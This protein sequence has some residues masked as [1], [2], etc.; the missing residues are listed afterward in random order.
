MVY[1]WRSARTT[2]SLSFSLRTSGP[3]ME[4]L[5]KP[6]AV[7]GQVFSH[8]FDVWLLTWTGVLTLMATKH[9]TDDENQP[10]LPPSPTTRRTTNNNTVG[11]AHQKHHHHHQQ[12]SAT[13]DDREP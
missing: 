4:L 11:T 2:L 13:D 12:Q 6:I 1:R 7:I 8:L 3:Y 5:S 10:L 9:F